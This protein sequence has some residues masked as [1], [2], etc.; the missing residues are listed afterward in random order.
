MADSDV[1]TYAPMIDDDSEQEDTG[2]PAEIQFIEPE[3]PL[4]DAD[5][6]QDEDAYNPGDSIGLNA[7]SV[8][9]GEQQ[10][11][12][13]ISLIPSLL[14]ASR[15]G[16]KSSTPTTDSDS[17]FSLQS[18][19]GATSNPADVEEQSGV[20]DAASSASSSE[21]EAEDESDSSDSEDSTPSIADPATLASTAPRLRKRLPKDTVGLLEDRLK[22][23]GTH[24]PISLYN[25]LI[26]EYMRRGKLDQARDAYERSIK[27]YPTMAAQW[28]AYADMEQSA[29]EFARAEEVFKRAIESVTSLTVWQHYLT[30]VR[31]RNNAATEGEAAQTAIMQA[32]ELVVSKVGIDVRAGRIWREYIE[33]V[34]NA[35]D[36]KST[37]E[38]QQKMD[39]M[40]KLYQR[41]V[42]IPLENLEHL[43]QEYNSFENSLNK[44]TARKFLA[45]RAPAYMTAR[46]CL[47]ELLQISSHLNRELVPTKPKWREQDLSQVSFWN[48]WIAWERKDP[49][50]FTAE[51]GKGGMSGGKEQVIVRVLYAYKQALQPLRFYPQMWF[52]VAEYCASVDKADD[53]MA[54]LKEGVAANPGSCLLNFRL[55]EVFEVAKKREEA[56]STYKNLA[57]AILSEINRFEKLGEERVNSLKSTL[58]ESEDS[59]T[60]AK[61]NGG[62][63]DDDDD[64]NTSIASTGKNKAVLDR[65]KKTEEWTKRRLAELSKDYTLCN[66]MYMR[67]TKRMEGLKAARLVFSE[68]RKSQYSTHHIFVASALMEYHHNNS[69]EIAGKI[70]ELGLRRFAESPAYVEQYLEFLLLTNDDTNARALFERT[71]SRLPAND[72]EPLFKKFYAYEAAYGSELSIV[73]KL[74]TRMLELY[75]DT[76]AISRFAGR[77]TLGGH[78]VIDE[79]EVGPIVYRDIT[80]DAA[81]SA[82]TQSAD[83][84][85][86][87]DEDFFQNQILMPASGS[88]ASKARG[89]HSRKRSRDESRGE[90]RKRNRSKREKA[91]S[92]S[93]SSLSSSV[94]EQRNGGSSNYEYS[95]SPSASVSSSW[96]PESVIRLLTL[97][98]PASTYNAVSFDIDGVMRLIEKTAIPSVP[99]LNADLSRFR[100]A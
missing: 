12:S 76:S 1:P 61:R 64:N 97:L 15:A 92:K 94:Q 9:V 20:Q 17:S 47:R 90:P 41:A 59:S 23:D 19:T 14:A 21:D 87:D 50:G 58:T 81:A 82:A 73:S 16:L 5:E 7:Q 74:E 96:I 55:A 63:L 45:D 33:F 51:D 43:W 6:E 84:D 80:S 25:E 3:K 62:L 95:S 100:K 66:T 40:R 91:E 30:Y 60:K 32:F 77:Y 99:P 52:D 70:F 39:L 49:L 8:P 2:A 67:A 93:A 89:K 10:Q 35:P 75:P 29:G 22:I 44:T 88:R 72:V 78:C 42:C 18:A 54:F 28:V 48:R 56:K 38:S 31:R 83:K 37:W 68:A 86:S 69:P 71:V 98:P 46:S 27:A 57:A 24:A 11:P 85:L 26:N 53:Q 65:I 36:G 13:P 34:K 79:Q 4:D